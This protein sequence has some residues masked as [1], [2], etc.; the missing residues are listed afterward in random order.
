MQGASL[1][2]SAVL[3]GEP[4][5]LALQGADFW[6]AR[7]AG[8]GLTDI[9]GTLTVTDVPVR[10]TA[11]SDLKQALSPAVSRFQETAKTSRRGARS[12]VKSVPVVGGLATRVAKK[13]RS[14]R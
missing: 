2:V 1:T 7:A 10:S 4:T 8:F 14:G 6:P 13:L 11:R 5:R 9:G 12:L 3:G